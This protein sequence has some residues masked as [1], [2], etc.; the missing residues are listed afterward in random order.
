MGGS[1]PASERWAGSWRGTGRAPK[2]GPPYC[3]NEGKPEETTAERQRN[4][5]PLFSP[6][7]PLPP[8]CTSHLRSATPLSFSPPKLHHQNNHHQNHPHCE[9]RVFPHILP[10]NASRC[11]LIFSNTHC[12]QHFFLRDFPLSEANSR[13]V[14]SS[15]GAPL[16]CFSRCRASLPIA[17]PSYTTRARP[18]LWCLRL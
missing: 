15:F 7:F 6:I 8:S 12:P 11:S 13:A 10:G 2:A 5:S 4:H 9:Y 3:A 17:S 14:C 1:W 16:F 18:C